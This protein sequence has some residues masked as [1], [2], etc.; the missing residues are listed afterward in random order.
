MTTLGTSITCYGIS[1]TGLRRRLNEDHFMVADLTRKAFAVERNKLLSQYLRQEVNASGTLLAVADGVGGYAGGA[2]ASQ[3]AVQATAQAL[4]TVVAAEA[5]S[6]QSL[7]QAIEEAHRSI[8]Q[9]HERRLQ[10]PNMASTLTAIHVTADGVLLVG[11]IGDSRAY[12]FRHGKLT[13]LTEDQTMVSQLQKT[14]LLSEQE[15]AT[16]PYKH[17]ILQALGQ[18]HPIQ[19]DIRSYPIHHGDRLLLCTDGLS[20]YVSHPRIEAILAQEADEQAMCRA[21]IRAANATG[22]L[23][24]VTVLI[25]SLRVE[26]GRDEPNQ[27]GEPVR[28]RE[29]KA[30]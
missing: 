11:Q 10:Y 18:D 21:L 4:W 15:V 23:D 19:P 5:P 12:L 13:V 29:R 20:S 1:D 17:I 9:S 27:G 7:C 2:L 3:I 25:A 24:N 26:Q 30:P 28:T 14:G 6:Q 8:Q 16:H 22:G